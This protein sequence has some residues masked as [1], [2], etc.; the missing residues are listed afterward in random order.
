[1]ERIKSIGNKLAVSSSLP[2]ESL[3][4]KPVVEVLGCR[5][6]LVENHKGI[7]EYS[8]CRIV[9]NVCFGQISITGEKLE[10]TEMTKVSLLVTG[11]IACV[12]FSRNAG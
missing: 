10:L 11:S 12:H 6:V 7:A 9:V 1:M 2:S 5:R 4:G 8:D 3:P